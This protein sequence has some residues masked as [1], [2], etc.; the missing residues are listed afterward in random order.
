MPTVIAQPATAITKTTNDDAGWK[1]ALPGTTTT[2][3]THEAPATSVVVAQSSQP[4]EPAQA[5]IRTQ[6][7]RSAGTQQPLQ[8]AAVR[9]AVQ[10][11]GQLAD[12]QRV[13]VNIV[14][15]NDAAP[16]TQIPAHAIPPTSATAGER[17]V[18]EDVA[19]E[20]RTQVKPDLRPRVVSL[21][22]TEAHMARTRA[23]D[24]RPAPVASGESQQAP[25]PTAIDPWARAVL[26]PAP[27]ASQAD[28]PA[29]IHEVR[30]PKM[31]AAQ[32][33][34]GESQRLRVQLDPPHLGGCEI[35]LT[36]RDGTVRATMIV[37]RAD[38]AAALRHV[39]PLIRQGLAE[40]GLEL[41]GFDVGQG[42]ADSSARHNQDAQ[43]AWD[44]TN[45]A[46]L[47]P[48]ERIAAAAPTRIVSRQH[49]GRIDLVA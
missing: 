21:P 13:A 48:G 10:P 24:D 4:D 37:E 8:E 15:H 5:I 29:I 47:V 36:L 49:S 7:T 2:A 25:T 45:A 33:R 26:V 35:E 16:S 34:E 28:T 27:S 39:E 41:S 23:L 30:L 14:T 42:Q 38:T 12:E 31:A 22:E 20:V 40:R 43:P 6:P 17:A 32:M 18:L 9:I 46:P 3:A 1:P 44:R 11:D 19:P